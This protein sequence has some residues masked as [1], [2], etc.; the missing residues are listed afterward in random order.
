[1]RWTAT[2]G[3]ETWEVRAGSESA[4]RLWAYI[5]GLRR[6]YG[7]YDVTVRPAD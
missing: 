4:A 2:A 1:M 5:E 7:P 6:G 3:G